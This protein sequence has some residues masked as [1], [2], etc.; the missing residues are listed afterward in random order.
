ML[1]VVDS[2][3][4][5]GSLRN[6]TKNDNVDVSAKSEQHLFSLPARLGGMSIFDPVELAKVAY[7]TSRACT[8][9]VVNS[10]KNNADFVVSSY[11]AHVREVKTEKHQKLAMVQNVEH[12]S[13]LVSL[14][15]DTRCAVQQAIMEKHLHG[16]LL[17]RLLATILISL[18]LSL[19]MH[20]HYVIISLFLKCRCIV[21]EVEKNSAFNMVLIVKQVDMSPSAMKCE[22]L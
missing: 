19:E 15:N 2:T 7:T 20:F 11:S 4:T 22:M 13:V 12:N 3:S 6:G 18:L 9:M 16:L 5:N 1:K 17:C 8:N 10:I 14:G 21:M